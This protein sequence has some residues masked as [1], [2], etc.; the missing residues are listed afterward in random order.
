MSRSFFAVLRDGKRY[1]DKWPHHS[2]VAAMAESR[3]IPITR[4][5]ISWTPGIAVLNAALTW[6]FMPQEQLAPG[7]M[8]SL[9]ML[10]LPLQGLYWL[11]WRSRQQLKPMLRSWYKE[12]RDKLRKQGV[13]CQ[14]QGEKGP[15]YMDL[16]IILRKALETLPPE[17]H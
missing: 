3:I 10:S 15:E 11:G 5:A 1:A 12:L 9:I 2:V 17:E 6:Q 8:L 14:P 16:A 13:E 4:K 7:L